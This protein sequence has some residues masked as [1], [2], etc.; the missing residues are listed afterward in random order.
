MKKRLFALLL[1]LVLCISMLPLPVL[2]ADSYKINGKVIRWEDFPLSQPGECWDYA[3]SIYKT[4]WGVPF[5]SSFNE[6]TNMLRNLSDKDLTLT[7]AHLKAYVSQAK[8]GSVLRVCGSTYLHGSDGV[9][10]SQIIV[11]KDDKGFTVFEGG[12]SA[13]PYCR[14]KYY[15]WSEYVNTKWLGGKYGYIKYIKWPDAPA[16]PAKYIITYNANGGKDAPAS[17][18]KSH[19]IAMTVTNAR[20]YR[21]GYVF[22]TW[23]TK[24]NGSGTSYAPGSS[25]TK[26]SPA[27]LYAQWKKGPEVQRISGSSRTDTALAAAAMLLEESGRQSFQTIIL[28]SG[29]DFADA[30]SGSYLAARKSAPILLHTK[31]GASHNEAFIRKYLQSGGTVYILGGTAA[32]PRG[33]ETA[34][35]EAGL[36]V[37][38]L[39]GNDRFETNLAVLREAGVDKGQELLVC[40]GHNFA[41]CL[42]ASATGLPILLVNTKR[43]VLS[44][45]QKQ[46]LGTLSN[47]PITIIGG[48]GAVS[49]H[50]M[51]S[52]QS[53]GTV[54]RL[55]GSNR[56]ATSA[57]IAAR[58]FKNPDTVYTASGTNF[59][60]GL[61]G[62]PLA[63]YNR[64][65]I[66]LTAEGSER[67]AAEYVA[68]KSVSRGYVLGGTGAVSKLTVTKIFG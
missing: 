45:T 51:K 15:T 60:D 58:Y 22:T 2:A 3:Q 40:T 48:T 7:E 49:D 28:A 23:N 64:S 55:S 66:L 14:E 53:S 47:S 65:P 26:N 18:K 62:G 20:P 9:G 17:Q 10:H 30:L 39:S 59:P 38:R 24:A 29:T 16:Y 52:L 43:N 31:W 54:T 41:D 63:C 19:N 44:S 57:L 34:L 25:Y 46:F 68:T 12:L 21:S 1:V 61:C 33:V 35:T 5:E 32:I 27:T 6:K 36:T 11:Q 8:L 67:W 50:L 56:Y 42:S 4:I 37:K 13:Y